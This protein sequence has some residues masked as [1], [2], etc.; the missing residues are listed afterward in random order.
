MARRIEPSRRSEVVAVLALIFTVGVYMVNRAERDG[1]T[2]KAQEFNSTLL[3]Q[4]N[5]ELDTLERRIMNLE[6]GCNH[7]YP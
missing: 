1:A 6:K 2:Q 3:A 7:A 5:R 4:R